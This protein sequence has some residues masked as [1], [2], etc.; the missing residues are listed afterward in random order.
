MKV[1]LYLLFILSVVSCTFSSEPEVLSEAEKLMEDRPDSSL[2]L[3]NKN[4]SDVG[5]YS[6]KY[7][8]KY[9]LLRAEAMNKAYVMM[10]TLQ[11]LPE[12]LAYYQSHG[13][14]GDMMAANYVMGSVY[15]DRGNSP[16]ALKYYLDAVSKLD[17]TNIND[18]RQASRIYAQIASL[19]HDQRLPQRAIGV[20]HKT[21]KLAMMCGDTLMAAEAFEKMGYSYAIMNQHDTARR[22]AKAAYVKYKKLGQERYAAGSLSYLIMDYLKKGNLHQAKQYINEYIHHSGLL[23]A[24]GNML[25]GHEFFYYCQGYYYELSSMPDSAIYYYRKLVDTSKDIGDTEYGYQGLASTYLTLGK[26][27]SVFKYSKLCTEASDS[28]IIRHSADEI[29][30]MQALYDYNESRELAYKK[31]AEAENWRMAVMVMLLAAVVVVL[32]AY[33]RF[34]MLRN[35]RACE[36]RI[37][38]SKYENTVKQYAQA[39]SER[40]MLES[41]LEKF[42]AA[43]NEEINHLKESIAALSGVKAKYLKGPDQLLIEH[44]LLKAIR[45]LAAQGKPMPSPMHEELM[46]LV[47]SLMPDFY[48]FVTRSDISLNDREID[49][50]VLTRLRF[51]PSETASLLDITKQRVTNLRSELNKR[52]FHKSGARSFSANILRI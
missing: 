46:N 50:C 26:A 48:A 16:M 20:W 27:D 39:V 52:I 45:K 44:D 8:M 41:D 33:A 12:V 1:I 28:A 18:V 3:L 51:M 43:K 38:K 37:V 5:S 35:R 2:A 30:R 21:I 25:P 10:D 6:K 32:M 31:S 9:Y 14:A 19:F 23:D 36:M 13:T 11:N 15:R 47:S 24:N 7:R 34:K 4:Q 49:V 17:T 40:E 22:I 42:K 29:N